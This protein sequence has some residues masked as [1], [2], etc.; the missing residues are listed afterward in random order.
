MADNVDWGRGGMCL[1]AA[2]ARRRG[3]GGGVQCKR[4]A[5]QA[6]EADIQWYE[7]GEASPTGL[8]CV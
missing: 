7:M 5:P 8:V 2:A 1:R 4:R 6:R 3:G